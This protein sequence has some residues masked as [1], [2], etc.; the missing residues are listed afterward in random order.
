MEDARGIVRIKAGAAR[1][2]IEVDGRMR[3]G[4]AEAGGHEI[5][6]QRIASD[7]TGYLPAEKF[8]IEVGARADAER[9]AGFDIVTEW[10]GDVAWRGAR[11]LAVPPICGGP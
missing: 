5:G 1:V 9:G 6:A 4:T 11:R 2:V 8:R 3:R 7:R 10:V